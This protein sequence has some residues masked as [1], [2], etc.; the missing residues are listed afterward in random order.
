M[1]RGAGRSRRNLRT[2]QLALYRAMDMTCW[3]PQAAAALAQAEFLQGK[4]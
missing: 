2:R 4:K 3:L 1:P